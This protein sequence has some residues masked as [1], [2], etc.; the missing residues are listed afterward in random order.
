MTNNLQK[1]VCSEC[2]GSNNLKQ[3]IFD[4]EKERKTCNYCGNI[5]PCISLNSLADVV[6]T[7]YRENYEQ[8]TSGASPSEIISAEILKLDSSA[9]ELD[10]DLVSILSDREWGSEYKDAEPMYDEG[11]TYSSLS[12]KYAPINDG[13]EHKE[14]WTYFCQRIKHRTRFFNAE[15]TDWLDN[16]FSDIDKFSYKDGAKPIRTIRPTD[17]DAVFFRARGAANSE[18]RIKICCHP[19]QELSPPPF[20]L[21]VNGR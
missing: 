5:Q 10:D 3:D 8:C 9:G 4:T 1:Y 19:A 12:E 7:V 13:S 11:M 14:L 20:H 18:E 16:I 17:S 6:D 21:A 15:M 2:A